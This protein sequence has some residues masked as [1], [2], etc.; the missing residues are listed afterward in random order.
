MCVTDGGTSAK[1]F[2][3]FLTLI[4][5]KLNTTMTSITLLMN[6]NPP[7]TL[8]SVPLVGPRECKSPGS[9][10]IQRAMMLCVYYHDA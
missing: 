9:F 4:F 2:K 10:F 8:S 6:A 7:T 3:N 1:L 5:P